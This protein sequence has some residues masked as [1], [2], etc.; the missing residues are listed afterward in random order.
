MNAQQEDLWTVRKVMAWSTHFLREKGSPTARLDAEVLLAEALNCSRIELYTGIDKPLAID[1]RDRYRDFVRRRGNGE[2]VAYILGR[3]AFWKYDF[4]VSGA[5]LIPRSD[6]ELLVETVLEILTEEQK[7]TGRVLDIGT[8]SGCIAL[9]LAKDLPGLQVD[10][11]DIDEKTLAVAR[12][13]AEALQADN[14]SFHLCDGL[15]FKAWGSGHLYDA[16]V[17]NPPYI[18]RDEESTLPRSVIG[19]EPP[20]ALFADA[21]GLEFYEAFAEFAHL[22]LQSGGFLAVEV[23]VA[24]AEKVTQIFDA[25]GWIIRAVHKDLADIER[26]IVVNPPAEA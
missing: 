12:R 7:V 21:D 1:E 16:I 20:L 15:N 3:K 23:G 10:A 11:W 4:E 18:R 5:T 6:T 8:G 17:S 24:Q 14:I 26:V 9:S 22:R 19:Y 13:N 2:P 25:R